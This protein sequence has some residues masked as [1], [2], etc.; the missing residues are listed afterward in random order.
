MIVVT[1][2]GTICGAQG[3]A[4][5]ERFGNSRIDWFRKFLV[6]ENGIASHNTFGRVFG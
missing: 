1:L 5:I 4:D 2:C 3:W 6:L